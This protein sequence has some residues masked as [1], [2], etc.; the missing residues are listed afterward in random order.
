MLNLRTFTSVTY[1]AQIAVLGGNAQYNSSQLLD[2]VPKREVLYVGGKYT[3]MTDPTTNSTSTAMI[4]QIY[5]EKL[6]PNPAPAVPRLPII[7]IAGAAQ[8]GTNFLETP[9]GRPG[10]ASY[11]LSKGH[12][13]YLSDQ[14]SR[15]RSFWLPG[16]GN[17]GYIGSPDTVSD[18]FTDVANNGDQWPQAKLHTQWPGSGRIGDSTFDNFYR[19]QVQLQTDRFISE[20]QN[21]Q[22][23]SALVDIVG[24]CY[25]ISHSQA[26]AYGWRVGD[27]RSDVVK[28]II[29]LEPSGPPFTLRPPFGN[30]AA[31]AFGLTDLAIAYEPSAGTNGSSIETTIEAAIDADHDECIMQ[32][33]PAKQVTNLAKIPELVV[34]G[35][36]SFHAPYDYCTVRYLEQVGVEVE[37]ADLGKEGIHGNGHMFFMEKNNL[38]IAERVYQWL[39]KH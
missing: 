26:G 31:F 12:T 38:E 33:S 35:E 32:K 18:I 3:N 11:F 7:F 25:I 1:L 39:Q 8:T 29:Q 4:G 17:M 13:V 23:Y 24:K 14:P 19:S 22:A 6:S 21:A 10:W 36:A 30:E 15:G 37:Y 34:T 16:Q 28:G 27:M 20:E 2:I 5:V 9:D